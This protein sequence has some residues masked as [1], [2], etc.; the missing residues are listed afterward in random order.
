LKRDKENKKRRIEELNDVKI[1]L[2]K[3][4]TDGQTNFSSSI[5]NSVLFLEGLNYQVSELMIR[6]LFAQYNGFR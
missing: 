3:S 4:K 1:K 6:N 5:A 2:Q